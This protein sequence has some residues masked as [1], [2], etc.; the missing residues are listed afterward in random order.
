MT[1]KDIR[2]AITN[3]DL[4]EDFYFNDRTYHSPGPGPNL[5]NNVFHPYLTR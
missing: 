3:L 1:E 4:D 2:T 5:K